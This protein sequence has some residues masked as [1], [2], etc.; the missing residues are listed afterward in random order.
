MVQIHLVVRC[1]SCETFQVIQRTQKAKY[2]CRLCGEP[3]S[4]TRVFASGQAKEMRPIVQELNLARAKA[5]G[6]FAEQRDYADASALSGYHDDSSFTTQHGMAHD[7]YDWAPSEAQPTWQDVAPVS[8]RW[9][10]YLDHEPPSV[11]R[12]DDEP[13]DPRY[14]TALPEARGSQR[15][16]KRQRPAPPAAAERPQASH[17]V[18]RS[19]AG[20]WAHTALSSAA[21]P[22]CAP[23]R[24]ELSTTRSIDDDDRFLTSAADTVVEE[25]VWQEEVWE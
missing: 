9:A 23:P 18:G 14:T 3:Q 1:Y 13:D 24:G 20:G 15:P 5:E 22:A 17:G 6:A 10:R 7:T 25:E 21:P 2:S 16:H 4:I 8:S 11:A 19:T 12:A